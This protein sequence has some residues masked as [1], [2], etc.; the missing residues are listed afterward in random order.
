MANCDCV[1]S[2]IL[3]ACDIHYRGL[4]THELNLKI[5]HILIY[6]VHNH[7]FSLLHMHFTE[8]NKDVD[9]NRPTS[10]I[11]F[12][13]VPVLFQFYFICATG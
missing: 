1:G 7:M 5:S 10:K 4:L 6:I 2:E 11:C 8:Q 13:F 9:D 3:S 12:S